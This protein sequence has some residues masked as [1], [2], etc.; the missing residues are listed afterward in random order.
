MADAS[1]TDPSDMDPI[2]QT[3]MAMNVKN[4]TTFGDT[5][6]QYNNL[7]LGNAITMQQS[8]NQLS[9]SIVARAVNMMLD[10]SNTMVGDAVLDQQGVKAAQTT[11]PIYTD[12][13]NSLAALAAQMSTVVQLLQGM[14]IAPAATAKA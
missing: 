4:L 13:T 12:P 1:V 2:S 8:F 6:L 7:A 5:Q 3:T 14:N 10:P 11:P 9:L